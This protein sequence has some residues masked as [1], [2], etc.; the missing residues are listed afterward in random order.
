MRMEKVCSAP[1][2]MEYYFPIGTA[3]LRVWYLR[4]KKN[5]KARM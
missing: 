4:S 2:V 1:E 3:V 5:A